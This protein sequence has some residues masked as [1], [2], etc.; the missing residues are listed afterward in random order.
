MKLNKTIL[1]L[2]VSLALTIVGCGPDTVETVIEP[3]KHTTQPTEKPNPTQAPE[4]IETEKSTQEPEAKAAQALKPEATE[5]PTSTPTVIPK[6]S[7]KLSCDLEVHCRQ[8]WEN[9]DLISE[10]KRGVVPSGGAIFQGEDV[11]FQEG[12]SVFDVLQRE[13]YSR[14]IHLEFVKTPMFNS[15]YI[16]G[17]S[18]LYEFDMGEYSGWL[19]RV[20]GEKPNIGSSQY[21]LKN[22]DK[23]E[24]YYSINYL[25]DKK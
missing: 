2:V 12:E 1:C 9:I 5:N 3:P 20:N 14:K 6:S 15:V 11:E 10:E 8:A 18:N 21:K 16:E 17:I 23:I 7:N 24:V 4:V 25:E 22:G 19:Y 13:L